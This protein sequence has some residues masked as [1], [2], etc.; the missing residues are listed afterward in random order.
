MVV[1]FDSSIRGKSIRV[2]HGSI[3][4]DATQSISRVI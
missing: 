1:E 4:H 2:V 3:V